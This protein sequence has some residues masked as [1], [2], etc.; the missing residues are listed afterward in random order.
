MKHLLLV[1]LFL[2]NVL[3]LFGKDLNGTIYIVTGTKVNIREDP[4]IDSSIMGELRLGEKI[5]ISERIFNKVNVYTSTIY[6]IENSYWLKLKDRQGYISGEYAT[7]IKNCYKN[8]SDDYLCKQEKLL[9]V[10]Y[11]G[12]KTINNIIV[13]GDSKIYNLTKI[14]YDNERGYLENMTSRLVENGRPDLKNLL[15]LENCYY[16]YGDG[17]EVKNNL[18]E[19]IVF[20][21]TTNN[22][23]IANKFA[24]SQSVEVIHNGC[25]YLTTTLDYYAD[26]IVVQ[27]ETT[28]GKMYSTDKK[29]WKCKEEKTERKKEI[30]KIGTCHGGD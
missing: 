2:L 30:V 18:C 26:H 19:I 10:P 27:K 25:K 3:T 1:V 6:E 16:N 7:D 17:E 12:P 4:N 8:Y 29:R 21:K 13:L 20:R 11:E 22:Y 9:N 14:G 5:L 15:L 24:T 23:C 28:L